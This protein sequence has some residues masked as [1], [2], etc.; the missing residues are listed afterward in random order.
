MRPVLLVEDGISYFDTLR[1]VLRR[2]GYNVDCVS[3]AQEALEFL[4]TAGPL[5]LVV[6][7]CRR[8]DPALVA[9][10]ARAEADVVVITEQG[11]DP[12]GVAL[13]LRSP[14]AEEHLGAA[15]RALFRDELL[16][17]PALRP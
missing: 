9:R 7:H 16:G 10:L 6:L 14:V 2:F 4:L 5:G 8:P 1:W 12:A 3:G 11:P 13:V 15:A 17:R